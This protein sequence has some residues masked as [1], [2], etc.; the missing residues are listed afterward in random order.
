MILSYFCSVAESL[1]RSNE[2]H[3]AIILASHEDHSFGLDAADLARCEI[4]KDAY[5]LAD[6]VFR[7]ILLCDT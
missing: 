3:L 6:H 7:R 5:L 1:C 4:G 2:P